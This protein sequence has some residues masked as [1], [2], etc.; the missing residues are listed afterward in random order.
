MA[1]KL[2]ALMTLQCPKRNMFTRIAPPQAGRVRS[3]VSMASTLHASP[4]VFDK[5]KAGRPEV[6]ELFNSLEGWARDNIL[7]HLKSVEN[8]WQPQDYLPDP[9]SDAFE[10][11]VK[12]MRERAKDIPDEYFVVLVGDMITEE[13]LPTYMSMLNRCDGIKDDTGAQP[14]S[15]ATWTRAWTAEENRHGDL[16][17]KY[18]YL[19]GRVDMRMI[20]KTIQ[21]L[22][23]SGMDT[24]TENCPYMGFIYTS[25]QERATFISHANTAKLAQ[26]YGDKNLAQVCGN[27]ASDEKRH[28]TAY[29]KIVEKL[30]EIDPDTTVIAF[31]DMMRKKIQMPAHAMY[32]GSD[33]MLFK[34]FTAVAQ[35]IGVY[36]AWDYC[37]IIDFL[38]DKWNVAKMTGLSGEGRKAQEYVCSLAA[39][40]RRVEE[41]VQGKEKKA[42]LPVA[43]SW[44]FNRQIII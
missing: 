19:S 36:S 7:V 20:E 41:K 16:L 3:K 11:Q 32:D 2:N 33:D 18:L 25:F 38:V 29:T 26:H 24:K 30:A 43:F 22:I 21:Y 44:I 23:G 6:D 8:S 17:N 42:V 31:S 28:A 37:D 34:H 14:T 40:I 27:I 5:L 10:D 39:K 1:M 12:E 4:L 15:W 35:Q 13:A 9:T